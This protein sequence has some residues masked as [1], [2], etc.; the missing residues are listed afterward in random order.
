MTPVFY[1]DGRWRAANIARGTRALPTSHES[2]FAWR[3][4]LRNSRGAHLHYELSGC[5]FFLVLLV[6]TD[7]GGTETPLRR[8]GEL[9]LEN[10]THGYG[11]VADI[12]G[13][14]GMVLSPQRGDKTLALYVAKRLVRAGAAGISGAESG[15]GS[16]ACSWNQ[17]RH[18]AAGSFQCDIARGCQ[19]YPRCRSCGGNRC[20]RWRN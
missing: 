5:G 15:G 9:R 17:G 10:C 8:S 3:D 12:A 1:W 6:A 20:P 14:R 7:L 11:R 19:E 16:S 13:A 2:F 4:F 18:R